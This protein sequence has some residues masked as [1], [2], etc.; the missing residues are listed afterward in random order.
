MAG[1]I[2]QHLTNAELQA[3]ISLNMRQATFRASDT[4]PFHA[5]IML[6]YAMLKDRHIAAMDELT[7]KEEALQIEAVRRKGVDKDFRELDFYNALYFEPARTVAEARNSADG[8]RLLIKAYRTLY[9]R[10]STPTFL[11]A[12]ERE[13]I[14]NLCGQFYDIPMGTIEAQIVNRLMHLS[15]V[16]YHSNE[17]QKLR[18][19]AIYY[20]GHIVQEMKRQEIPNEG[21]IESQLV[22]VQ[23][24]VMDYLAKQGN[25]DWELFTL[26]NLNDYFKGTHKFLYQE[27]RR[28][29]AKKLWELRRRARYY[30]ALEARIPPTITYSDADKNELKFYRDHVA[31]L[32]K[33]LKDA[34]TLLKSAGII[35]S[36]SNKFS[37]SSASIDE[38]NHGGPAQYARNQGEQKKAQ[39]ADL[40]DS[41]QQKQDDFD[42]INA[43]NAFYQKGIIPRNKVSGGFGKLMPQWIA[44]RIQE[45]RDQRKADQAARAEN[46]VNSVENKEDKSITGRS[47]QTGPACQ[48][49]NKSDLKELPTWH[50]P[51]EPMTL[52]EV[53]QDP[54]VV[55]DPELRVYESAEVW[56]E[57]YED[58]KQ[59]RADRVHFRKYRRKNLDVRYHNI[60]E[61]G[62]KR[63]KKPESDEKQQE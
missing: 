34:G 57:A 49:G 54:E 17:F 42:R 25:L 23:V 3:R 62:K 40:T 41:D 47:D 53:V 46:Q 45:K 55:K 24:E 48:S 7:A 22:M 50:L 38:V 44:Q 9:Y 37:R 15:T 60:K 30:D 12:R 2:P 1:E 36:G 43:C 4:H 51:E 19:A 61:H 8:C 11:S 39:S 14:A 63:P 21:D 35:E 13:H 59:V 52:A 32:G 27:M 28:Y 56:D 6:D 18:D 26:H 58:R 29:L 5:Q 16:R 31:S 10:F 33:Q 20:A